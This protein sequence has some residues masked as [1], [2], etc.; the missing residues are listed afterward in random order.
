[1]T[2]TGGGGATSAINQ[3]QSQPTQTA[4]T[5]A[6]NA[7]ATTAPN[8][9]ALKKELHEKLT[10]T[11]ASLDALPD[12][13]EFQTI[14]MQIEAERETY[15]ESLKA[16]RPVGSRLDS[17][18][19]SL[20]TM[21]ENAEVLRQA[22]EMATAA[23]QQAEEDIASKEAEITQLR[24]EAQSEGPAPIA[25]SSVSLTALQQ[26]METAVTSM[27]FDGNQDVAIEAAS[28]LHSLFQKLSIMEATSSA[29][30][31]HP[32]HNVRRPSG[33]SVGSASTVALG[34]AQAPLG[35]SLQ[36]LTRTPVKRDNTQLDSGDEGMEA[37][38]LFN[39]P[40]D[41]LEQGEDEHL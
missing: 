38:D 22:K 31:G 8:A 2:D 37:K 11:Q 21:R 5:A 9:A 4:G 35:A 10:K 18:K 27:A 6:Q 13:P 16:L 41:F 7:G 24:M 19:Q 14:R 25:S 3:A 34:S 28:Q 17:A 39:Y 12:S 40:L 20:K 32:G 30:P 36:L 29:F 15:K 23:L 33:E 26:A 1:M